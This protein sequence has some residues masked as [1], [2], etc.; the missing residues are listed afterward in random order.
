MITFNGF[1]KENLL[2]E[3][4]TPINPYG[5]LISFLIFHVPAVYVA[6]TINNKG[7]K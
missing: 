2:P 7:K 5:F 4:L 3:T 6:E 1:L